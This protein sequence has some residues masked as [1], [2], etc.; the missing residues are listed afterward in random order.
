MMSFLCARFFFLLSF[1]HPLWLS[2]LKC[3]KDSDLADVLI[4]NES[5]AHI[6]ILLYLIKCNWIL[7]IHATTTRPFTKHIKRLNMFSREDKA[8]RNE[9]YWKSS[10]SRKSYSPLSVKVFVKN[11][12]KTLLCG[13]SALLFQIRCAW[14]CLNFTLV[15][16]LFIPSNKHFFHRIP[17]TFFPCCAA[18]R[19]FCSNVLF[20]YQMA[21]GLNVCLQ[22]RT[23]DSSSEW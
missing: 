22:K 5:L 1:K 12:S 21:T 11:E 20:N 4:T 9:K 2:H 18:I 13:M 6:T 23:N 7:A 17:T 16:F 8:G 10:H 19:E 15:C 3:A 14:Y